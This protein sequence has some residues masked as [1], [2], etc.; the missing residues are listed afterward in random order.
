MKKTATL[1]LATLMALVLTAC[2]TMPPQPTPATPPASEVSSLTPATESTP[3]PAPT[4][5]P[6]PAPTPS[7]FGET[8]DHAGDAEVLFD[9]YKS[10]ALVDL[11]RD[12]TPEEVAFTAGGSTSTLTINGTAYPVNKGGLAQ[13]FAITDVDKADSTLEIAFTDKYSSELADTEKPF[14]WLFWWNGTSITNMGGL[15]DVRFDG[16]WRT[17]FNPKKYFN[18]KGT[19]SCL[20]RTQEFSD[21]WY[22]GHYVPN[23]TDRKLKEDN[24]SAKPINEQS[25]LTLKHLCVLLKKIDSKYFTFGYDVIWDYASSGGFLAR[26]YTNSFVS[27]VPQA[28][29]QL[30]VINVY[31]KYWFKLRAADG[32]SGWLKC[33][34]MNVQGYYQVDHVTAADIFDGIVIAG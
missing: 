34:D 28:G 12:G 2:V 8:P 6:T 18:A 30:K 20:T 1:I 29:E 33:V 25:P 17:G 24:Y 3:T 22:M 16:A 10:Q 5:T 11:N 27:F 19:V 14:T 4:P 26:D 13:C 7:L 15:M 21:V 23:G 9:I 32:K 31:G